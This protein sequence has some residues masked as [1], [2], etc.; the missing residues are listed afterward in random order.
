MTYTKIWCDK[1][2]RSLLDNVLACDHNDFYM[3][4]H[5]SIIF[6]TNEQKKIQH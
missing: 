5:K 3:Q 6:V 2:Q 1:Q 4:T